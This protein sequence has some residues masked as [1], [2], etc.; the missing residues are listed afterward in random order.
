ME[1]NTNPIGV[2]DS[3]VG[4][5]SVLSELTSVLENEDFLYFGDSYNAPY[6]TKTDSEILKLSEACVKKLLKMGAKAIVIAC[7][8]ATSVCVNF[9]REKY[10]DIPIIGIE[11]AIKPAAE[12]KE[13]SKILVMAT[14]MTLKREKF[15]NL[16]ESFSEHEKIISLPCPGLVELIEQGKTDSVETE[17]FLRDLLSPYFD[18]KI[19]S[20]VLGCTHY[21]FVREVIKKVFPYEVKIFDGGHGTACETKRRIKGMENNPRH[22]GKVCFLN[23]KDGDFEIELCKKL[24]KK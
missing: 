12:Y 19:D 16:T 17:E 22:K 3:G 23:S 10:K 18:E 2:F 4:G 13:N 9:L 5:V 7:N 20:V 21:P 1:Y 6:G 24:L 14:P 8:T 15:K 11:P